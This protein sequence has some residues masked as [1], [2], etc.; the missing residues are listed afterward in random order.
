MSSQTYK[1]SFHDTPQYKNFVNYTIFGLALLTAIIAE[2][3]SRTFKIDARPS[4]E[5]LGKNTFISMAF[6]AV[7]FIHLAKCQD[8]SERYRFLLFSLIVVMIGCLLLPRLFSAH[9]FPFL[10]NAWNIVARLLALASLSTYGY[11][12][13]RGRRD[14][15]SIVRIVIPAWLF[16]I[17]LASTPTFLSIST[18][19]HP[20]YDAF[21]FSFQDGFGL[22]IEEFV[23]T[24]CNKLPELSI[25]LNIVYNSLPLALG[26]CFLTQRDDEPPI[27]VLATTGCAIAYIL[28]LYFPVIG[29]EF[30]FPGYSAFPHPTVTLIN[31]KTIPRN[32]M[33]S[34]HA[35]MVYFLWWG[36][37]NKSTK[38]LFRIY[39]ILTLCAV[40][41][42]GGHW[43][44]DIVVAL[45]YAVAIW[46]LCDGRLRVLSAAR[47][48][49]V[50][51]GAGLVVVWL[52]CLQMKWFIMASPGWLR[53]AAIAVTCIASGWL[54]RPFTSLSTYHSS[55]LPKS[56][57][58]TPTTYSE[59]L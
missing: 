54:S 11:Q 15:T 32:C 34:M 10:G 47:L 46:G 3:M 4:W 45:P 22:R 33:P 14:L 48:R 2:Y 6:A 31:I 36:S 17:A 20:T 19:I 28:Y 12:W 30:T 21:I 29:P 41:P 39:A 38:W 8:F 59:A 16:V 26:I 52:T 7:F 37:A 44:T 55:L 27:P 35:A 18:W 51:I 42:Y 49:A 13:F 58:G 43:F 1:I 23:G 56:Q 53:W 9:T 25:I 5:L 24:L 50:V 57:L 40:F